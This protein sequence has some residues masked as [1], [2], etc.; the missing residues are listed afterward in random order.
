MPGPG[1][2][3]YADIDAFEFIKDYRPENNKGSKAFIV[4][5]VERFPDPKDNFP[6]PGSYD[7]EL[8]GENKDKALCS[9]TAFLSETDRSPYGILKKG[10]APN[11]YNPSQIPMQISFHFNSENRW[12]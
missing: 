9:G 1:P 2:G 3:E 5:D 7:Y 10:A 6:G 8:I 12:L 11:K 4:D